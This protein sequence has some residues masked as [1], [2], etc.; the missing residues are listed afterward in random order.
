M[1]VCKVITVCVRAGGIIAIAGLLLSG[2]AVDAA[3]P[4]L[5]TNGFETY[6]LGDLAGQQGWFSAGS[7]NSTATIQQS[8]V[9]SGAQALT[10]QRAANSDRRW[11]VPVS[12]FP[13]QRF[14]VI[15]WD[16]RVSSTGASSTFG[17]FFGVEAYDASAATIGLLG[18][19]GVDAT[20]GDILYQA[21]GTGVLTETGMAATFDTWNHYRIVLDFQTDQYHGF[22]NGTKVINSIGFVDGSLGLDDFT[23]ADIATFAAAPGPVAAGLTAAA[24]FDNFLVWDGVVADFDFD[25]DVDG[26]DLTVWNGAFDS[27]SAGDADADQDTD[28]ADFL[29]WQQQRG[30]NVL[31]PVG[32]AG[33]SAAIAA[34]PEPGSIVL[35]LATALALGVMRRRQPVIA[36]DEASASRP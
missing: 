1:S 18:S 30:R 26:G 22:V 8:T 31:G 3:G 35:A 21:A 6:T 17:P 23:D 36:A 16:M 13:T 33:T 34:V 24:Q 12:G 4:I 29:I 19:L 5:N 7:G 11:A 28:G 2:A 9:L 14:V 20:T 27:S 32:S 25:G 10:V 15:D